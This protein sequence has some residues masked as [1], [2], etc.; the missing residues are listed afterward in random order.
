MFLEGEHQH[1]DRLSLR[2]VEETLLNTD[3]LQPSK[4]I[5]KLV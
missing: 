1:L 2:W 3:F 5:I 4:E